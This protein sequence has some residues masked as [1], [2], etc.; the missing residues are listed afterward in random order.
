MK[1]LAWDEGVIDA[2][3]REVLGCTFAPKTTKT[4]CGKR[5]TYV[6]I[7]NSHYNCPACKEAK[8]KEI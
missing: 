3:M 4:Y 1:H 7:D 8:R 5:V 2:A 6:R